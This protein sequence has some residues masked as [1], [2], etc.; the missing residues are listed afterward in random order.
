[1]ENNIALSINILGNFVG[2]RD[3]SSLKINALWEKDKKGRQM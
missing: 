3:I 2:K 1:M